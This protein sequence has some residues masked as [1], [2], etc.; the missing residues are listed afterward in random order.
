MEKTWLLFHD[1]KSAMALYER[2][3]EQGIK[4][5]I[6]PT[7]REASKCCG[8]CI[9]L[10]DPKDETLALKIAEEADLE[11]RGVHRM[12]TDFKPDRDKYC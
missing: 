4:Q 1:V 8:V 6:A 3:K 12:E 2:L 7:P 10:D 11:L 5:S 9:L